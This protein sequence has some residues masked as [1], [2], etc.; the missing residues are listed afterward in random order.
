MKYLLP[1]LLLTL[2]LTNCSKKPY[3]YIFFENK[4]AVVNNEFVGDSVATKEYDNDDILIAEGYYAI[5]DEGNAST[6]KMG[7]W[8]NYFSTGQTKSK[9]KY[10]IGT[11]IQCCMA[12]PCTEFYNYK[13][14][15][16][17]YYFPN[18]QLKATGNYVIK[19]LHVDTSCEG[20]DNLLFGLT[21]E[22]WMYFNSEGDRIQPT[23]ELIKA[24]E[25]VST[26]DY[27]LASFFYPDSKKKNIQ[28]EFD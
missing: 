7:N 28:M 5:D 21:S 18:G 16:W 12:G 25:T 14:G 11:Y 20:G 9:G 10:E 6:L 1:L 23:P 22:D 8:V 2:I 26:G 27:T 17:E 13:V 19:E 24:L 15:K 3:A 4:Y